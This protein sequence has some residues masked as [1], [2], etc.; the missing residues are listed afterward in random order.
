[1]FPIIE[2]G[3]GA[4][5]FTKAKP[6]RDVSFLQL[7]AVITVQYGRGTDTS[8]LS[9]S[10]ETTSPPRRSLCVLG[11]W[12]PGHLRGED[13]PRWVRPETA[14]G[15]RIQSQEISDPLFSPCKP[16]VLWKKTS[17]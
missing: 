3:G 7:K 5:F 17:Q 6:P 4:L 15:G 8:G 11:F 16:C 9:L 1:M 14:A 12:R 2:V 13:S 10:G